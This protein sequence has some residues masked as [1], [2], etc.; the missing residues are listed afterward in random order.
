MV[1]GSGGSGFSESEATLDFAC[2]LSLAI[3]EMRDLL[4]ES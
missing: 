4:G 3:G 2:H 1:Q